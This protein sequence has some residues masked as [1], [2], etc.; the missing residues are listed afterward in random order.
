M[1]AIWKFPVQPGRFTL[2]L[3]IEARF[4]ALQVQ[5][6]QPM[7]WLEVDPHGLREAIT[8]RVIPTGVEFDEAGLRYLG[9]FQVHEG[10]LVFH[11]Y[12]EECSDAA[13][14]EGEK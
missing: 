5:H 11:V 13:V 14:G 7:M 10:N 1:K 12:S 3:P 9:T 4:R 6:G 2:E 8:F